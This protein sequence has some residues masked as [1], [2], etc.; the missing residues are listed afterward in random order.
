M[1]KKLLSEIA[2]Y[3]GSV[4]MPK[5]FE[6]DR[7]ILVKNTSLSNFYED[8]NHSFNREFD[9]VKTYICD[10]MQAYHK[11]HLVLQKNRG[12]YFERNEKTKPLLQLDPV[13]L[14]NSADFVCLY[15]VETD[16]DTCEITLHYDD[17]R[18]KGRSWTHKLK[19]NNYIIFPS[20]QL[21]FINNK[22]NK[23]LNYVETLTFQY[24]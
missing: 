10:Y 14:R 11:L 1:N 6:I 18:R 16:S 24:I 2:F 19:T 20:T 13:D 7:S 15:G 17:N 3:Y 23:H 5:G 22:N 4:K 21:Y 12:N 9:K 8:V